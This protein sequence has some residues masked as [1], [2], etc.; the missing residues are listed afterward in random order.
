MN[1]N[2]I[3]LD[4]SAF[5]FRY[6]AIEEFFSLIDYAINKMMTSCNSDK[7]MIF[8]DKS[9]YNFRH[10][11]SVSKVYKGNRKK[12]EEQIIY[13]NQV[14]Q[15]LEQ[16]YGA[17]LVYGVE[18]DD[19]LRILSVR[20]KEQGYNPII[21]GVDSDLLCIEGDHFNIKKEIFFNVPSI[22]KLEYKKEGSKK[23]TATGWIATYVKMIT[24][25]AKENFAGLSKY[26][27]K[28]AYE[29]LKDVDNKRDAE[30]IVIKEYIKV[31]GEQEGIEKVKEAFR[32]CYLLEKNENVRTPLVYT[33][34]GLQHLKKETEELENYIN[35]L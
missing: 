12:N 20:L 35:Y 17:N 7:M 6:S 19:V 15:Y 3:L 31:F 13:L 24:G 14:F 8:I 27:D 10:K 2:I 26:G 33:K 18:V 23:L 25:A 29:M 30:R 1:N 11:Y 4:G 32:L 21:A 5:S 28:K 9:K 22:P 34:N 16:A